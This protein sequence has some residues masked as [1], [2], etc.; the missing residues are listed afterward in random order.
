MIPGNNEFQGTPSIRQSGVQ[1]S[2]I[3]IQ[4]T[5][6]IR[7]ELLHLLLDPVFKMQPPHERIQGYQVLTSQE[8]F[9]GP[10]PGNRTNHHH[11]HQSIHRMDIP[12]TVAQILSIGGSDLGDAMRR[13]LNGDSIVNGDQRCDL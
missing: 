2:A 9:G 12:D 8:I 7:G 4:F 3:R 13:A 11:L 5:P 6:D 1:T 10:P